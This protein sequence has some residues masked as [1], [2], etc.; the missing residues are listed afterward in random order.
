MWK[1]RV[2]Q[3]FAQSSI[4]P[5][6]IRRINQILPDDADDGHRNHSATGTVYCYQM[7]GYALLGSGTC[8][9]ICY[10]LECS[11]EQIGPFFVGIL[12]VNSQRAVSQEWGPIAVPVIVLHKPIEWNRWFVSVLSWVRKMKVAWKIKIHWNLNLHFVDLGERTGHIDVTAD[13]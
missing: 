2:K 6:S 4:Q 13:I 3:I 1:A 8:I 9:I 10:H 7:L 12:I 11:T 5:S